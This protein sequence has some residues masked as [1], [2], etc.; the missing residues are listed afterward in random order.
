MNPDSAYIIQDLTLIE[1]MSPMSKKWAGDAHLDGSAS[2]P[3]Q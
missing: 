1:M 3:G 2:Y